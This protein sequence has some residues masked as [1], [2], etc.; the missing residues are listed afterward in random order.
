[1]GAIVQR[2]FDVVEVHGVLGVA[3]P[4]NQMFQPILAQHFSTRFHILDRTC[5]WINLG[6]AVVKEMDGLSVHHVISTICDVFSSPLPLLNA[7]PE[8][9]IC[10]EVDGVVEA[11][12]VLTPHEIR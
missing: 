2:G 12:A 1:M 3:R 8:H 10:I 4:Q 7:S 11:E 6:D 5:L 9:A